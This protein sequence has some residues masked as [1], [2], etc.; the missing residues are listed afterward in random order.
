M[1]NT[2]VS[3]NKRLKR[4]TQSIVKISIIFLLLVICIGLVVS[5]AYLK[6]NQSINYLN[7]DQI[8]TS[9]QERVI[10]NPFSPEE[11]K[12]LASFN[13]PEDKL[14]SLILS[15]KFIYSEMPI[16]SEQLNLYPLYS[17]NYALNYVLYPNVKSNFYQDIRTVKNTNDYLVLVNKNYKL[18]DYYRPDDLVLL[19]VALFNQSPDNEANYLRKAAATALKDLFNAA[20]NEG[21]YLIARSGFRSYETQISL[22]N[23]YVKTKGQAYA[24]LYSARAGHSEHQTG[25]TID[26][27]T[28]SVNS[29]L[30]QA[31]GSTPEGKWIETNAHHF[32]FI[33]RYPQDKKD[34]VGYEYEPWH[35][36]YVG[37]EAATNIYN[38]NMILEDYILD[39][40]LIDNL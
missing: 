16:Y 10:P 39:Q 9:L 15:N 18:P 25:L 8:M 19:D 26:I 38:S 13:I 5:K 12:Y 20:M 32:G 6:T 7:N 21:Y 33:I 31:F 23:K 2:S 29:E 17:V 27:T 36:R 14:K 35:L 34:E 30:I 1:A 40:N 4:Q 22:Y 28:K 3:Q 24:D 11:Q 37:I